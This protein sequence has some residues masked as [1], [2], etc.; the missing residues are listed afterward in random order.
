MSMRK[1]FVQTA[2]RLLEK[3]PRVV[4]LLGDIGV[5]GFKDAFAAYPDRVYNIGILEQAT[6]SLAAGLAKTGMVPIVHTIAPFLTE[7]CLEQIKIDFGYQE[8]GGNFV[9]VG[10]SYD[11]AALGCTHHCP[12]DVQIMRAIPGMEIV[13]PGSDQEFDSLLDASYASPRPT[14]FRLSEAGNDVST[15]AGFGE[16]VVVREGRE[17]VVVAVG[18]MLKPVL[19]ATEGLDVSVLYYATVAPFDAAALKAQTSRKIL[20]C[21]PYYRGGLVSEITEALWPDP[22]LVRSVGVPHKFLTNYGRMSEHDE[23]LGFTPD[24]IRREVELL[25]DV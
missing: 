15:D 6:V 17:A 22:V 11:Y 13:V 10:A 16:A 1:Q 19:K 9:T 20:L 14:Y 8:L 3:D 12:G 4:L 21:E 23:A 2:T 5:Y 18:P 24:A 7:R 25:I